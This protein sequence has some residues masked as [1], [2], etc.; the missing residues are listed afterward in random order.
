M[1]SP[2]KMSSKL[3]PL[4]SRKY[5]DDCPITVHT[6]TNH[7]RPSIEQYSWK[8]FRSSGFQL[9][10][11]ARMRWVHVPVNQMAWVEVTDSSFLLEGGLCY[12][13]GSLTR[14]LPR[15]AQKYAPLD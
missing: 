3:P 14:K 15:N 11:E 10:G 12:A 7:N 2:F 5:P 4:G 6:F 13:A 1:A 9:S 8:E